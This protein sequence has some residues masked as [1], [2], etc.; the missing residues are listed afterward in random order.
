MDGSTHSSVSSSL[1]NVNGLGHLAWDAL[2]SSALLKGDSYDVESGK[3]SLPALYKPRRR[4]QLAPVTFYDNN[5]TQHNAHGRTLNPEASSNTLPIM[6][7]LI[8]TNDLPITHCT[9]VTSDAII[10]TSSCLEEIS[11]ESNRRLSDGTDI[12][13]NTSGSDSQSKPKRTSSSFWRLLSR[14][15]ECSSSLH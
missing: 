13:T 15:K 7:R 11:D 4:P 5:T 12:T 10:W 9:G 8:Q 14:S 6:H 2:E 1:K 3:S